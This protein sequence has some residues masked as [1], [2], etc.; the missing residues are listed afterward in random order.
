[1]L[2]IRLYL[3]TKKKERERVVIN[4]FLAQVTHDATHSLLPAAFFTPPPMSWP[5][6]CRTSTLDYMVLESLCPFV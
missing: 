4:S 5:D 1:M 6:S 2:Y 3:K